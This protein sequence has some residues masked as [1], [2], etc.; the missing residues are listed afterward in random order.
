MKSIFFCLF[1]F[2]SLGLSTHFHAQNQKKID[3]LL[4][5]LPA[6]KED[7]NKV[8]LLDDLSWEISYNSLKDG[9]TYAEQASKLA[10][11]LHYYP[12][13]SHAYHDLG[14]IYIDMGDF[15]KAN[16]FLYRELKLI[17]SGK[18]H[19]NAAGC[20]VE[21]GILYATQNDIPKA[22]HFDSLALILAK[23]NKNPKTEATT[24]INMAT[25]FEGMGNFEKALDI[26]MKAL[27]LNKKLNRVDA[28]GSIYCNM[29]QIAMH[30]KKYPEALSYF[31]TGYAIY[32][33]EKLTYSIPNA[34][35]CLGDYY[36]HTD[37]PARAVLYYDSA[38]TY[39]N[40]AGEKDALMRVYENLSSAYESE[41]DFKNAHAYHKLYSSLKDSLFNDT[42]NKEISKNEM[43]YELD[44]IKL[45]QEK[46]EAI[47]AEEIRHQRLL[48]Y[49]MLLGLV[50]LLILAFILFRNYNLKKK[51]NL[52][53]EE[54]NAV[55]EEKNKS[56]TD[57]INYAKRIQTA[58]LPSH[59]TMREL[60]PESFFFLKPKDIVSGD[61]YWLGQTDGKVLFSAVDCTGHGVPGALVS[62]VAYSNMNRCIKEYKLHQPGQIL[63][64]LN[65]LVQEVFG[66]SEDEVKDGMDL[67][68]CSLNRQ[69]RMLEYAGA[70]NPLWVIRKQEENGKANY[71][72]EEI[73]ADKQPIGQYDAHKPFT[74]H[75]IHLNEGDTIYIFSDGYADQFGGDKGKKFKYKKLQELLLSIQDKSMGEQ[76]AILLQ[77]F[78]T[79]Q[80]K[81]EQVDDVLIIGVRV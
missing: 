40:K 47:N 51:N 76:E 38:V 8:K 13:L 5:V 32:K 22:L 72:L 28:M 66:Q 60:L 3:S 50:A 1:V 45:E 70:N 11:H 29:G 39:L 34:L 27:A 25:F 18:T 43:R 52:Q 81:L 19:D 33:K 15:E 20:Y 41:N 31:K 71:F 64:K 17:E 10:E 62:V 21:L 59:K 55:I 9:V 54:K 67:S 14:S 48:M 77:S 44:K 7:T 12:G 57:S 49:A 79:W 61:F 78:T 69:T 4:R 26:N 6:A 42:K 68:L 56:I 80:D 74:N 53:L 23:K 46:K 65:E 35:T 30:L 37:D 58:I 16:D 24:L 63:D 2:F 75:I 36:F 73:K